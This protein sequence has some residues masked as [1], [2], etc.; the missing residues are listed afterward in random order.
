MRAVIQR[1]SRARV[2][3]A[4]EVVGRIDRGLAVLLGVATGDTEAD[5]R[6]M[7]DKLVGLRVFDDDAGKMNRSLADVGGAMLVVSQ[8]TLLGDCRKG[9]RPSF[10]GAAEPGEA[11][12]LYERFCDHVRAAGVAVETGRFR[13]TMS[14]ELSNEGP[15]T[16]IVESPPR[17]GA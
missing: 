3:V 4:G 7:A 5:A 1:V 2:T 17:V 10:V 15:V 16:L 14:V 6:W 11:E 13:T 9:R 12:R 8:F